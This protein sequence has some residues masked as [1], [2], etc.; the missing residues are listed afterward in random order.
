MERPVIYLRIIGDGEQETSCD[1]ILLTLFN[2]QPHHRGQVHTLSTQAGIVQTSPD[3]IFFL[4]EVGL[5]WGPPSLHR[6]MGSSGSGLAKE[7]PSIK[8][9]LSWM[10]PH[11]AA[12]RG[13]A[14]TSIRL[15]SGANAMSARERSP[16]ASHGP[17]ARPFSMRWTRRSRRSQLAASSSADTPLL[18]LRIHFSQIGVG[19][20]RRVG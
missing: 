11:H 15:T 2:R 17:W 16:P 18:N 13:R 14:R 6:L 20:A 3:I 12:R 4:E 10:R 19:M 5:S 9:G 7:K 8:A 1:H